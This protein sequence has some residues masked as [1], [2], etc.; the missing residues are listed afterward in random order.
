MRS[1]LTLF[2]SVIFVAYVFQ[3]LLLYT[4]AYAEPETLVHVCV[5]PVQ[6]RGFR[7]YLLTF[8]NTQ[9][10]GLIVPHSSANVV[11]YG[12]QGLWAKLFTIKPNAS[13]GGYQILQNLAESEAQPGATDPSRP[14]PCADMDVYRALLPKSL[15]STIPLLVS[16]DRVVYIQT[17]GKDKL[18][19]DAMG[20][21]SF[22][23]EAN[24]R[25]RFPPSFQVVQ[26]AGINFDIRLPSVPNGTQFT[27]LANKY[28]SVRQSRPAKDDV[29]GSSKAPDPFDFLIEG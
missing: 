10:F 7:P 6:G 15:P 27:L 25:L 13:S 29:F 21:F 11:I 26:L 23:F 12:P 17:D 19:A 1:K 24:D 28:F 2:V 22:V 9:L 3:S 5:A 8:R 18:S 20:V 16:S 4:A 14:R